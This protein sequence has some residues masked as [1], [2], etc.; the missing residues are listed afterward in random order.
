MTWERE[1]DAAAE[2]VARAMDLCRRVQAELLPADAI[3]KPDASPVTIADFASQALVCR[4]L[5]DAFPDDPVVAEESSEALRRDAVLLGRVACA[6]GENPE[7]VCGWIDRGAGEPGPRFWTLDP[8]DGTKGFLRRGQYAIALGL[9]SG[10]RVVA[11]ALGCPNLPSRGVDGPAGSGSLYAAAYGG[12]VFAVD[13]ESGARTP[14]RVDE[15]CER[16]AESFEVAHGDRSGQEEIAA[17]IGLTAEPVRI[18]SQAKYALVAR[19]DAGL[20]LRL[21]PADRPDFRECIWDHAAGAFLVEEAGGVV[22]DVEGKPLDFARGRRLA[23]NRGVVTAHPALHGRVLAALRER[24][25]PADS[26]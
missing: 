10:G 5:A 6:L 19:G 25:R 2:A 23:G 22:T 13:P 11:A 18:D 3:A 9:I 1:R 24:T 15:R 16:W 8:I 7:R 12:G 21:P 17:R 26:T 20:I 4:A 14:V